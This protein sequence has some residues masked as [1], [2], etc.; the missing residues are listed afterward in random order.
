MQLKECAFFRIV[1]IVTLLVYLSVPVLAQSTAENNDY[2]SGR[3]A[4]QQD[5]KGDPL[6]F[7]G[8]FCLGGLG[9]LLALLTEPN[10]QTQHLVGKSPSFVLGY[11]DGYQSKAKRQNV[12]YAAGGMAVSVAVVLAIIISEDDTT[13]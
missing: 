3:T 12:Y 2:F 5:G 13:Y 1:A 7:F 11:I 9:V 4:G 8:G 6:W 10:P